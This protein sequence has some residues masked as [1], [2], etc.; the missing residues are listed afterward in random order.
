MPSDYFWA[1]ITV[2]FVLNQPVVY[3]YRS[4]GLYKKDFSFQNMKENNRSAT[5]V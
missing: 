5:E 3:I 1:A 2:A 4:I